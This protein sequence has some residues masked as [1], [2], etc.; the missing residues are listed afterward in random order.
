MPQISP[1]RGLRFD[2]SRVG[3]VGAALCPPYDVITPSERLRL[4]DQSPF[5]IVRVELSSDERGDT[6]DG[7]RYTRAA[8]LLRDWRASGALFEE[9]HFAYYLSAH[10][11]SWAGRSYTRHGLFSAV[12][13]RPW[14]DGVV[15]PH[16]ETFSGPK[17]DR[18]KLLTATN[19]NVSPVFMVLR[20]QP[21]A[22]MDAWTAAEASSPTLD[23]SMDGQRQRLWLVDDPAVVSAI[24]EQLE[25]RT[26]YVAD[27]HHR[28]ETALLYSAERSAAE[29]LP[30][31]HPVHFVLTY[32]A[33][34]DDPDLVVLP[35]HRLVR[36][37]SPERVREIIR[38]YGAAMAPQ[39]MALDDS[40]ALSEAQRR[41]DALAL[42]AP[43]FGVISA[44]EGNL[45][46]YS[47]TDPTVME[48]LAPNA[49]PAWRA[50]DVSVLQTLVL[51]PLLPTHQER[52]ASVMYT[53]DASEALHD[54][55]AGDVQVAFLMST[56]LVSAMANIADAHARMPEK[57]TY[58]YPKVPTGLVMRSIA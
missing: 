10:T 24:A 36:G 19:V 40:M 27:G 6:T 52:D 35:T 21:E 25:G 8:D 53:R 7:N 2:P 31:E 58:F 34:M 57:S 33:T 17:E 12:R 49:P 23:I 44:D 43:S 3:D 15:L 26:L 14:A 47:L 1:F 45:T 20:Q 37:V 42:D 54:I 41:L 4:L 46:L 38:G 39:S 13:L 55:R 51:D 50:L 48:R 32:I 22:L 29:Q 5:N 9:A 18:F 28:Y 16:E 30:P 56:P 11:F